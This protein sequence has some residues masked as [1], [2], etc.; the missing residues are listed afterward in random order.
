MRRVRSFLFAGLSLALAVAFTLSGT[1][2]RDTDNKVPDTPSYHRDVRPIFQQHCQGCH[3]PGKPMGSYVM[4]SHAA[5]FK[6]GDQERPGIVAGK[7]KGSLLVEQITPKDGKAEM[8]KGKAPLSARD[9]EIISKWIEQGAKDD[10]PPA[11]RQVVDAEHPPIYARPPVLTSLTFSPDGSLLAVSGY[12]E[13]L[14]WKADGSERVAR[15]VG[16][17]ER[18]QSIAFSADGKRLAVAGGSPARF[19]EI[20]VWD[21]AKKKL[22]MSTS[23]TYDTLFGVSWAP[24]GQKIAF[25]CSDNTVRAIEA[26]SGKQILFSNSH[27]DWVLG[28]VFSKDSRFVASVSRD[29]SVRLTELATQRFIDNITSITPGALKGGLQAIAR[30]PVKRDT[31]VNVTDKGIDTSD[32]FYDELLIA[33]AD[34]TPK[35]YKMHREKKRVIG[36]DFNKVRVYPAL[37][38][39]VNSV[40]FNGDGSQYVAGSSLDGAGEVV[41][42][43]TSDGKVLS[44]L[45]KAPGPVYSVAFHPEGKVVASGGFDGTVR[46]S[47]AATGKIIKEFIPVPL[48]QK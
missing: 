23:I 33:G 41:V 36:D 4:T 8:P 12:H 43:Q 11:A 20:Q 13:V 9:L 44:K 32:R 40:C 7:P 19:G 48:T 18:V 31:K 1:D 34:G 3:Q 21:L 26:D 10:T 35:L 45:E 30:N 46:L 6:P 38:G 17:S 2:A 24:D 42:C 25:G 14:I 27:T 28:T 47:D 15:L 39:R 16:L 5:L 29:G 37:I 22:L